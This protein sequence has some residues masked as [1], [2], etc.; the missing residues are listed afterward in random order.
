MKI[1]SRNLTIPLILASL[2]FLHIVDFML[3]MPLGDELMRVFSISPAEFSTVVGSYG[4]A[5]ALSSFFSA[6]L[7]DRFDRKKAVLFISVGFIIGTFVCGFSDSYSTL[8]IARIITGIF[9]GM[10]NAIIFTIVGDLYDIEK[11]STIM[12]YIA[13]SFSVAS[14]LG[15]PIGLGLADSN[16]WNTPFIALGFATLPILIL[17]V[18]FLPK[19]TDHLVKGEKSKSPIQILSDLYKRRNQQLALLF[20]LSLVLGQFV[21]IPFLTPYFVRNV[22]IPQESIKYIYFAGGI[23][24]MISGPLV[25]RY[26]SKIGREKV[27]LRMAFLS[28]I[29]IFLITHLFEMSLYLLLIP[30]TLLFIF[31]NG[32]M[33]PAQALMTSIVHPKNRGSFMGLSSSMMQLG[34][35]F[36]TLTAGSIVGEEANKLTNFN[37]IGYLS[38]GLTIFVLFLSRKLTTDENEEN[39]NLGDDNEKNKSVSDK[40]VGIRRK[41]SSAT[42]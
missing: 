29:P 41:T 33:I 18:F 35:G 8:L 4:Y 12:G 1:N 42:S 5:A 38:I 19:M 27:F 24:T 20:M 26:A 13:A 31:F 40:Y 2:Q 6:F 9:G 34:I 39:Q 36:A 23:A 16:S 28:I 15:V 10:I 32:R 21:V 17:M 37:Y 7:I 30:S 11:R 22:G 14:A 3:I 25:G